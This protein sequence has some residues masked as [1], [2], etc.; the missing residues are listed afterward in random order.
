MKQS[1][2]FDKEHQY[3]LAGVSFNPDYFE[4]WKSLYFATNVTP[5]EKVLALQNLKRLDPLNTDVTK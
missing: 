2:L 5:E 3:A 4:A 1:K